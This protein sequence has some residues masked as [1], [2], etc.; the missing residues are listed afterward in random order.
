MDQTLRILSR[1]SNFVLIELKRLK[2]KLGRKLQAKADANSDLADTAITRD[3]GDESWD[4]LVATCK[5]KSTDFVSRQQLRAE[6]IAAIKKD[7]ETISSDA[8]A[9]NADRHLP[10]GLRASSFVQV[11]LAIMAVR[12]GRKIDQIRLL[13]PVV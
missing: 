2:P 9:G 3:A 8:V 12:R 5:H 1:S 10:I 4:G 13:A 6:E 11:G 7:V